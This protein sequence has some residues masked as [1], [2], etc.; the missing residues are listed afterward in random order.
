MLPKLIFTEVGN[1]A[2]QVVIDCGAVTGC[3][4]PLTLGA[5]NVCWE[6]AHGPNNFDPI[7]KGITPIR[8][9]IAVDGTFNGVNEYTTVGRA[10]AGFAGLEF[11]VGYTPSPPWNPCGDVSHDHAVYSLRHVSRP[12]TDCATTTGTTGTTAT[13]A[14][15]QQQKLCP[16]VIA[17]TDRPDAAGR[18]AGRYDQEEAGR[19][20]V[21]P[22]RSARGRSARAG[23]SP[24]LSSRRP[25]AAGSPAA[26]RPSS[27]SSPASPPPGG[28]PGW[29][30]A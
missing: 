10:R 2:N 1:P 25:T 29:R 7:T 13:K 27:R 8:A 30:S 20:A 4:S 5:S 15:T 12:P 28:A 11:H 3:P 9:G 24:S 17:P 23:P 18:A 21:N 14:V 6:V 22:P 19:P 26:G 16:A